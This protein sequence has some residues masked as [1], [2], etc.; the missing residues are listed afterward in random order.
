MKLYSQWLF[1][2]LV[3]WGMQGD[4]FHR[5]RQWVLAQPQGH[6][7]EI[8]FGTGLNLPFYGA[9]V[10]HL[11]AI[12]PN[13]GMGRLAQA[14]VA[15]AAFPVAVQQAGAEA[16]PYPE[17]VFDWAVSTWTLCSVPEVLGA[18]REVWRVLKPGGQFAFVEH[19]LS[20]EPAVQRWQHRLTPLQQVVGDGCRLNRDFSQLL[21]AAGFRLSVLE[22]FY[23]AAEPKILGYTYR[24]LAVKG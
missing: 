9:A 17:A 10:T 5:Q 3:D 7:L 2:R 8:G 11:A 18:L 19:G 1:P 23:A 22:R 20:E 21:P 16:L 13:P 4:Y 12:D 24:G 14:R 6:V 15:R